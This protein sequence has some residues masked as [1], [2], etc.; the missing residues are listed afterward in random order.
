MTSDDIDLFEQ[1]IESESGWRFAELWAG[2]TTGHTDDSGDNSAAHF[3]LCVFLAYW[4]QRDAT[5]IDRFFRC[6]GLMCPEWDSEYDDDGRTYGQ[7]IIDKAIAACHSVHEPSDTSCHPSPPSEPP[8]S[9]PRTNSS[10]FPLTDTGNGER[11]LAQHGTDVR[12]CKSLGWLFWNSSFWEQDERERVWELSKQTVRDIYSEAAS[13]DEDKRAKIMA[14]AKASESAPR[15]EAM[16]QMASRDSAEIKV[17]P[18][19]LDSYPWLF[20]VANGTLDLRT[21]QLRPAHRAHLLT[22]Q[23]RIVFDHHSE[24]PTFLKFLNAIFEGDE[25]TQLLFQRWLGYTLTGSTREQA[26]V[27]AWGNGSNG[28][29]TLLNVMRDL[30]GSYASQTSPDTLMQKR[31]GEGIPNDVARLRGARLVTAIE[32]NEGRQ[33]DEAKIK[34]MTGGDVVT[35][36]FLRK[37]FFEFKPEFKLILATNHRPQIT[38]A[39]DGIWRRIR[40]LP[41]NARFWNPDKRGQSGPKHL[42][43]DKLMPEKLQAELSGILNWALQGCLDWQR[44]GLPESRVVAEATAEYRAESDIVERFLSECCVRNAGISTPNLTLFDAFERW[45]ERQRLH[46]SQKEFSQRLKRKGFENKRGTGGARVWLGIG[47]LASPHLK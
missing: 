32:T 22:K 41:F 8:P 1:A 3:F 5:R 36:R 30:L 12:F 2:D 10:S 46:L 47:L 18:D 28:K 33:F 11:F 38:G 6:S 27:I 31:F 35:A 42:R 21:G 19:D 17:S 34:E 7:L 43:A 39:D 37:E 24:C 40:L 14:W 44:G 45:A 26:F 15:R 25:E 29:T 20:N 16:L 23:S 13:E 9:A 4:T